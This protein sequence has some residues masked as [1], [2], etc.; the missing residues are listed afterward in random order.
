MLAIYTRLSREDDDSNSIEN[1]T[2]EGKAFAKANG[3]HEYE[4]YNEGQGVSGG[5]SIQDRPELFRLVQDIRNGKLS[6]VWFRH[7]NRL[8]RNTTTFAI[9]T[10]DAKRKG[11]KLFFGDK[12]YDY[13]DPQNVLFGGITSAISQYQKDL[14][15]IQTK[16]TL[17]DNAKEGK[18]WSVVAYGYKSDNGY[19]AINDSEVQIVKRI[20][21]ESLEGVGTDTIAK[22]LNDDNIPT[23]KG[24][25]WRGRTVQGIIKNTLYKGERMYS[26]KTFEAPAIIEPEYWQK[27]N[28]NL[29]NNRN[30]S[31]KKVEHK[32]LLKGVITC[33]TCGKGYYGKVKKKKGVTNENIYTCV[34][35]RY[36][37]IKCKSKS[38]NR[39]FLDFIIQASFSQNVLKN[40]LVDYLSRIPENNKLEELNDHI[41]QLQKELDTNARDKSNLLDAVM[42]GL[43]DDEDIKFKMRSIKTSRE[44]ISLKMKS[45]QEQIDKLSNLSNEVGTALD[46][47]ELLSGDITFN[48]WQSVI[49]ENI[50]KISVY[51]DEVK[52]I[53]F[54]VLDLKLIDKPVTYLVPQN[55]KWVHQIGEEYRGRAFDKKHYLSI[56]LKDDIDGFVESCDEMNSNDGALRVEYYEYFMSLLD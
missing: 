34:G 19:L 41:E 28:D 51:W 39:P 56:I 6:A 27:V 15:S 38:I 45:T 5:A 49:K 48:D 40:A 12:E 16:R 3:F 1:Q 26:G 17:L 53:F 43:I 50:D 37:E 7:Q 10:D 44:D 46:K 42:K 8:E 4:L 52:R 18:V 13:S 24:V 35:K 47:M 9:F 30:N 31:G 22:R 54:L 33:G 36:P 11:V 55:M 21:R 20:Y 32:Y 29:A 14:Q 23:R 25:N 2:R